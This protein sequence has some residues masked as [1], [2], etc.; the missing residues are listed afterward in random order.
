MPTFKN[1]LVVL[2]DGPD[3]RFVLEK[4][5]V[6]ATANHARLHVVQVIHE[7]IAEIR[8]AAIEG[9]PALKTLLLQDAEQALEER[10]APFRARL[11]DL[12]TQTLWNARRW[13]AA[14]HACQQAGADLVIKAA[15][16]E[17]GFGSAIR[18]PDDWNLLRHSP[19]PVLLVKPQAW[20][21]EPIILCA[22]DPF[23][24]RHRALNLA[25]L[26]ESQGFASV[27]HGEVTVVVAYPLFEP[28]VGELGS[29]RSYAEI[30][31]D[32][33]AEIR[34]RVD[35][36]AREAGVRFR[37]LCADEGRPHQ[38]IARLVDETNA[39]LLVIGTHARDGVAG[40]LLGNTSERIL[41]N[42][43]TDVVTLAAR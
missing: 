38:V 31:L 4:A 11:A 25:L 12:D 22:L 2:D 36:L 21:P 29:L 30:K 28:W 35:D 33:E 8:S 26:Q 43:A 42:V 16:D 6:L 17:G 24:D 13:E 10:V 23:D 1:I 39:E 37:N 34:D 19:V 7:G 27:L 20:V 3:A 5:V 15:G 9:S 14:L 40:V 18:T 32:V 41:H